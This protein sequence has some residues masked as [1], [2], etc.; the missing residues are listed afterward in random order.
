M[1][2][3][4][5]I[6]NY[7]MHKTVKNLLPFLI[8]LLS[9]THAC[10]QW[11]SVKYS[12]SNI[13]NNTTS[14]FVDSDTSLNAQQIFSPTYKNSIANLNLGNIGQPWL[15]LDGPKINSG[16]NLGMNAYKS[17][18]IN[19]DEFIYIVPNKKPCTDIK[20]F[21]GSRANGVV[22]LDLV[23]TQYIK[24]K[25]PIAIVLN[26]LGSTGSYLHQNTD[27]YNTQVM[28]NVYS[29]DSNYIL[30]YRAAF[31]KGNIQHNGGIQDTGAFDSSD[32]SFRNYSPVNLS[33]SVSKLSSKQIQAVQGFHLG[34]IVTTIN[35]SI[36]KNEYRYLLTHYINYYT[37][38]HNYTDDSIDG[39]THQYRN[40]GAASNDSVVENRFSNKFVF[41][42]AFKRDT[43]DSRKVDY[44]IYVDHSYITVKDSF[45]SNYNNLKLGGNIIKNINKLPLYLTF[46][47]Y[48]Y[49]SGY[50]KNDYQISGGI[51]NYITSP[52]QKIVASFIFSDSRNEA[53]YLSKNYYSNYYSWKTNMDKMGLTKFSLQFR[54]RNNKDTSKSA[55]LAVNQ[56]LNVDYY[57]L[58]NY[59]YNNPLSIPTQ[60]NGVLTGTTINYTLQA[61]VFKHLGCN[62]NLNYNNVSDNY[63]LRLPQ[64]ATKSSLYYTG[65]FFNSPMNFQLG[66]DLFWFSKIRSSLWNPVA[67]VFYFD[68]QHN[69]GNYPLIDL[70]FNAEIY[71]VQLYLKLEHAFWGLPAG[72]QFL[73]NEY[74]SATAYPMQPRAIRFG[75]RWRLGG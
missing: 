28:G 50:N 54:I 73:P 39:L 6:Q 48:Y 29:K 3:S 61:K 67:G 24:K 31:S 63:Y 27:W 68:N 14:G 64:Y 75:L 59:V 33:N 22:S 70:F 74:Y 10:S 34:K 18:M 19:P 41:S 42:P 62:I 8:L 26:R 9:G 65:K 46:S 47:G 35:D 60:Y 38:K 16:F 53:N 58:R 43:F 17:Y 5:V 44:S 23:H 52:N 45:K 55:K 11:S 1:L 2:G 72:Y 40:Y 7:N 66:A 37:F 20:Y 56:R 32:I 21:Q 12:Y 15:S 57:M 36:V 13:S 25:Y 51:N 69:T 4:S 49:I 30:I 71:Q